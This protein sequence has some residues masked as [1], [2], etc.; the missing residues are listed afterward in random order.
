[1]PD[2]IDNTHLVPEAFQETM[3][4]VET[5]STMSNLLTRSKS[6]SEF[7]LCARPTSCGRRHQA[8]HRTYPWWSLG[9][10]IKREHNDKSIFIDLRFP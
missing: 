5:S 4:L 3:W 7:L 6:Q 8:Q 9:H 10:Q 1:M 2:D